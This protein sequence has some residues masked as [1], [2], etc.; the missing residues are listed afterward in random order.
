M[1]LTR[2]DLEMIFGESKGQSPEG[3]STEK[4]NPELEI[5]K[6]NNKALVDNV[7][8][9]VNELRKRLRQVADLQALVEE[10]Q[11]VQEKNQKE[12]ASY[13][14]EAEKTEKCL[15]DENVNCLLEL[16]KCRIR[17]KR[18]KENI[19]LFGRENKQL[20]NELAELKKE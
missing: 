6:I 1:R 12:F 5:L 11:V 17:E 19:A 2:E 13:R 7:Y 3:S 10:L 18:I 14:Q 9:L 15:R 20:K 16:E 4:I 8:C